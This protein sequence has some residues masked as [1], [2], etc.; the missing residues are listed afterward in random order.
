MLFKIHTLA[1][2]TFGF[3]AIINDIYD[4]NHFLMCELCRKAWDQPPE[5]PIQPIHTN[6]EASQHLALSLS[7]SN[8]TMHPSWHRP[9]SPY[10][11]QWPKSL[12]HNA[13]RP[14][15]ITVMPQS[16]RPWASKRPWKC[17]NLTAEKTQDRNKSLE[18]KNPVKFNQQPDLVW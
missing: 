6:L 12:Q 14:L 10:K 16:A 7:H 17:P 9:T 15:Q 4:F 2:K 11:T 1:K 5:C 18:E 3:D 8:N 13:E